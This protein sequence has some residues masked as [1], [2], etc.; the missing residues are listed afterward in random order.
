MYLTTGVQT[1]Q[2]IHVAMVIRRIIFVIHPFLKLP[3]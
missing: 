2:V 1:E 3:P